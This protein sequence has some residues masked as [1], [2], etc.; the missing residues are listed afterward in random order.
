MEHSTKTCPDGKA[1]GEALFS[2]EHALYLKRIERRRH[3]ITAARL[4]LLLGLLALWELAVRRGRL[5]AFI[6]S[7]PSRIIK[8]IVSLYKSGELTRHILTTFYETAAGFLLGTAAG[9]LIAAVL[10]FF[11]TARA[12][13]DPYL[14]VL[15]A[16]PKIALGPVLIVWVGA[17][18]GAIIVMALLVSTVVTIMTVLAGFLEVGEESERLMRT[19]GATRL[20]AFFKAV[21]PASIPTM[22]SALKISVGM[23]WVGVIVGEYLVSKQGLGYLIVYGGQVFRLDLVMASVA[24]LCILAAL[25]YYAVALMEKLINKR[26]GRG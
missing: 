9:T 20:Q 5:D 17:G 23:S 25:M 22:M 3:I 10:W 24:V 16:L 4:L 2:R 7:S 12:V 1:G 19:L 13:L 26:F 11:P 6:V 21:L 8:T 18:C 15:N 14:V